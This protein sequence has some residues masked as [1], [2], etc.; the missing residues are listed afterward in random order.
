[1]KNM[2]KGF[3]LIELM[4]VVAII[5]ILAAIAIPA[6]QD[7]LIR[8]QVSEGAVLSDGAKTAVSEFYS[9][10]GT[11]PT[12]NQSAGLP[13]NA[14]SISGKYVSGVN[15]VSGVITATFS[16][17]SANKAIQ[18]DTFTLSPT[19]NGGSINWTCSPATAV[20]TAVPQKYLPSSCRTQ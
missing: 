2:Q 5:A 18:G 7:Y 4:I 6:Y 9:N 12:G 16:G 13:T 17:A 14:A 11:W 19:D 1:M 8:S 3:T 15:V 10:H 20:G